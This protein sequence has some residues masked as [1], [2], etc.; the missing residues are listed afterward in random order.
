[1][2][3][4]TSLMMTLYPQKYVFTLSTQ[5]NDREKSLESVAFKVYK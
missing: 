3:S 5:Q 4:S 1:M 2:I